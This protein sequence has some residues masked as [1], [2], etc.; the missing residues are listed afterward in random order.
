M[1]RPWSHLR[2]VGEHLEREIGALLGVYGAR[3]S[4]RALIGFA[5][6]AH[7]SRTMRFSVWISHPIKLGRR[8]RVGTGSG[9]GR[10][11][12]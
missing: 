7:T 6:S 3:R 2:G 8:L 12:P 1:D 10:C 9:L 11:P 4:R 5:R